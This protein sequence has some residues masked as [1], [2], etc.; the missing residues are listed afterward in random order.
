MTLSIA[1]DRRGLAG[2]E[3]AIVMPVLLIL[4]GGL[5]DFALAF[6]NKGLLAESVAQG[7]QYAFLVGPGVSATAVQSVVRQR[8]SLPAAN[9][10]VTGP[11]CYCVSGTPAVAASQACGNPCPDAT[12]PGIYMTI[13]ASY[14]YTSILVSSHLTNPVFVENATVRLR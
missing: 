10:A 5:G 11:G 7:A 2:I 3:L 9:V 6:W 12:M 14:Q 13:S 4:L 1:R 8:L